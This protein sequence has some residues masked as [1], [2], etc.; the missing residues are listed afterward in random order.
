M[1]PGC[2]YLRNQRRVRRHGRTALSSGR[3]RCPA[4]AVAEV[5]NDARGPVF[6]LVDEDDPA[7]DLRHGNALDQLQVAT[8]EG[9]REVP[10]SIRSEPTTNRK[11]SW[12]T[13]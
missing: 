11:G 10:N 9:L 1:R 2:Q 5:G 8:L 3:R 6:W 7:F 13:A 12:A 4:S